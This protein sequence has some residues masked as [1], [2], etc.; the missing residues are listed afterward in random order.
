[1]VAMENIAADLAFEIVQCRRQRPLT[2]P[3][4]GSRSP[5]AANIKKFRDFP[6]ADDVPLPE[7]GDTLPRPELAGCLSHPGV[8][9][10]LERLGK[11]KK[12]L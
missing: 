11:G 6:T 8:W 5:V 1:M 7:L 4:E 10:G 2:S 9:G 3:Q 12:R